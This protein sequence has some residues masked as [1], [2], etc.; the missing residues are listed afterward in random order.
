[1]EFSF[2]R[3][4]QNSGIVERANQTLWN[5]VRKIC[6]FGRSNWEKAVSLATYAV[7]IS[8][9][10]AIGTFPFLIRHGRTPE[11]ETDKMLGFTPTEVDLNKL[12]DRRQINLE[13]YKNSI[14]KGCIETPTTFKVGYNVLV[15]KKKLSNKLLSCWTPGYKFFRKIPPDAYVVR[16]GNT[17]LRGNK[18]HLKL[19]KVQPSGRCRTRC[20][21][22]YVLIYHCYN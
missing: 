11:L 7:N 13:K 4:P 17:T 22:V 9:N 3:S 18:S 1:M 14:T 15:F 12:Y 21:N 16:S 6:H 19:D 2:T 8:F 20:Y 10:R 5:K